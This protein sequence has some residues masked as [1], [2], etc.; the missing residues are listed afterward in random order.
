MNWVGYIPIRVTLVPLRCLD[1]GIGGR[2]GEWIPLGE[3]WCGGLDGGW[4][5]CSGGMEGGLR[6]LFLRSCISGYRICYIS[7]FWVFWRFE[8]GR[9]GFINSLKINGSIDTD[10]I[11]RI[12]LG[13]S[14]RHPPSAC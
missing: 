5:K 8:N 4:M 13:E 2:S 7:L 10:V 11:R 9:N 14:D 1:N 6:K 3:E 12:Q